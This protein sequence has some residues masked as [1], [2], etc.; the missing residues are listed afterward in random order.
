M[1]QRESRELERYEPARPLSLLEEMEREFGDFFRRPFSLM[2]PSLWQATGV[3]PAVSM[4]CDIYEDNGNVMVKAELPGMTK[5]DLDVKIAND[6]LTISGQKKKEEKVQ[7]KDYY[8]MERSYGA[9]SRSFSLPASVQMEKIKAHF[10]DGILEVII[11]KTEEAM[12]KEKKI[13]IE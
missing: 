4:T 8:R 11:P 12:R 6:V 2:R 3:A 7:Q 13:K 10:K 1:A 9:F 5:E